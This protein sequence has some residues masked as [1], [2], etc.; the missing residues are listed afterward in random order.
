MWRH[1]IWCRIMW[2]HI[3]AP[4]YL[5]QTGH[6]AGRGVIGGIS[7]ARTGRTLFS[8]DIEALKHFLSVEPT[9]PRLIQSVTICR[10]VRELKLCAK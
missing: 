5:V 4:H 7:S 1:I 3:F 10:I 8:F 9:A 2:R 6:T